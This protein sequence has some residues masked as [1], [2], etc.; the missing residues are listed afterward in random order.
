MQACPT[1]ALMPASVLDDA[2]HGDSTD[3]DE[4]VQ[5]I[6]PFCGVGCQVSLKVKDGKVKHVEGVNGPANEGGFASRGGSVLTIS[7]TRTG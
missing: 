7:T 3:H 2:Q 4:A 5:S 1:G 6:C